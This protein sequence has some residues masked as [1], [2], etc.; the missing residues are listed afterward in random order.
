N[1][2]LLDGVTIY[3]PYHCVSSTSLFNPYAIKD[4][5]MMMGGFGVEYGGRTSSVLYIST[6]EGSSKE[7]HGEIEPGLTSS[8]MVVEFPVSKNA[9]IMISAR[10]YYDLITQFLLYSPAYLFDTNISLNWK[11]NKRNRLSVRY[12]NSY[13]YNNL[14]FS[15]YYTYIANTFEEEFLEQ[16]DLVYKN[17]WSNQAVTGI[18]KSII[19]PRIY[20]KTQVSGSFFTS[21]NISKFDFEFYDEESNRNYKLFYRTAISNKIRDLSAKMMLSAKLNSFNTVLVGTEYSNYY[22]GNDI[23]INY[24]SE[25]RATR[26]PQLMAHFIEDKIKY[27]NFMF[28]AGVRISRFGSRHTWYSEPRLN[29]SYEL[30]KGFK[31]KGAWGRYYQFIPSLNT[32]EYEISQFLDYYYPLQ[33]KTGL[34]GCFPECPKL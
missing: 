4:V 19:S 1:L 34:C 32:Q 3:N 20:L 16:Y 25:G 23:T 9:T 26:E 10:G 7:F 13:D 11:I 5:N 22:F 2:I 21:D 31:L 28:R 14:Q 17:R 27:G 12:F 24:F 18:L 6:R 33:E 30:F 8:R 29:G 15:E